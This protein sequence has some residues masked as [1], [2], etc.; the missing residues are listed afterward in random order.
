MA[1]KGKGGVWAFILKVLCSP[2]YYPMFWLPGL[3]VEQ[4][5]GEKLWGAKSLMK[6]KWIKDKV[7]FLKEY[8]GVLSQY[9]GWAGSAKPA[10]NCKN[11]PQKGKFWC[12]DCSKRFCPQCTLHV[13]APGTSLEQHSIEELTDSWKREGV[14]LISPILP[15]IMCGLSLLVIFNY[16]SMFSE[17]YL[18]RADMCPVISFG[19]QFV[20]SL[21]P[22]LFYW[23][24]ASFNTWCNAEDSFWKLL[25]DAWVRGIVT[26]TDSTLLVL[27]NLPQALLFEVVVVLVMVPVLATLYALLVNV[28]WVIEMS[29]P[30]TEFLQKIEAIT[31]FFDVT[32]NDWF[33]S[34]CSALDDID[35]KA[36]DTKPRRRESTDFMDAIM[37]WK[38]RKMK[39]FNYFYTTTASSMRY[40]AWQVTMTVV[41][42]RLACVWF[43]LGGYV[44]DLCAVFGRQTTI[45]T[46]QMWFQDAAG[47]MFLSEHHLWGTA[48]GLHRAAWAFLSVLPEPVT[49]SA[50]L[51]AYLLML[52]WILTALAMYLFAYLIVGQRREF[53]ARWQAGGRDQ[54]L[55]FLMEGCEED[56]KVKVPTSRFG[57]RLSIFWS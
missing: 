29:I 17:D 44:R 50:Y 47:R 13:H 34:A 10:S 53:Q 18:S 9:L 37:Y 23:Y 48:S 39:Y 43:S 4:I 49:R 33:G 11:C 22:H 52:A 24:K 5:G 35:R 30:Q 20:A 8:R 19:R 1:K 45:A 41:C 7:K 16:V 57:R 31:N 46:H 55:N 42:F 56:E 12:V 27:M 38:A 40:F 36:P 28:I 3:I 25:T 54:A 51:C 14:H 15:E 21:D 32:T 2:L 26:E 6:R